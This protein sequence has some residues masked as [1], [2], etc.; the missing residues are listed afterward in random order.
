MSGW[1]NVDATQR[2]CLVRFAERC[3]RLRRLF[4]TALRTVAA[5]DLL[6]FAEHLRA[7]EQLDML[8]AFFASRDDALQALTTLAAR[9]STLRFVDVSFCAHVDF[10]VRRTTSRTIPAPRCEEEATKPKTS[11]SHQQIALVVNERASVDHD[12]ASY[13]RILGIRYDTS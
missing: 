6:A 13:F 4:L 11:K 5:R 7:L 12:L 2:D 10:L 8:G 9:C 1:T 3:V